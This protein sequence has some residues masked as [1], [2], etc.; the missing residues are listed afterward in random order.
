[1]MM[2]VRMEEIIF[3]RCIMQMMMMMTIVLIN[4][5]SYQSIRFY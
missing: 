1:M 4:L 2:I 3:G 5:I